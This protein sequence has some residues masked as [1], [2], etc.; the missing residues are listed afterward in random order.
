MATSEGLDT[1]ID[2]VLRQPP[3]DS[4]EE[5]VQAV[6][7]F[8]SRHRD[9]ATMRSS[10]VAL[11]GVL[12]K[13][14][15][16]LKA[17]LLSKDEGA[18]FDIANNFDVRHRGADQRTDYDPMFLEWLFHWYLATV[19]LIRQLIDQRSPSLAGPASSDDP[20]GEPF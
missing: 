11:A 7:L 12:E 2:T 20:A 17:E 5:V 14:R 3:E 8:R 1:A 10:V 15:G 18:L 9:V 6:A 16:L 13:Y 4:R 19:G